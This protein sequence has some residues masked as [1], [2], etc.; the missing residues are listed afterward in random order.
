MYSVVVSGGG[1]GGGPGGGGGGGIGAPAGRTGRVGTS[2]TR[3]V[4]GF[5]KTSGSSATGSKVVPESIS[6]SC[7]SADLVGPVQVHS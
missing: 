7:R 1:P 6:W 5:T 4:R 2:S 3:R